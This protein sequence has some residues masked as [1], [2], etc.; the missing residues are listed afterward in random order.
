MDLFDAVS[1]SLRFGFLS[2]TSILCAFV[3]KYYFVI[4][5]HIKRIDLILSNYG[6]PFD[7]DL[8]S[9]ESSACSVVEGPVSDDESD[10]EQFEPIGDGEVTQTSKPRETSEDESDERKSKS[11]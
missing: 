2:V 3:P 9:D 10:E 1:L 8:Q 6:D 7:S 4:N 5:K 11:E